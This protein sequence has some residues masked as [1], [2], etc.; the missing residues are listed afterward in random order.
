LIRELRAPFAHSK[1]SRSIIGFDLASLGRSL[2]AGDF[3][4]GAM[5]WCG[6]QWRPTRIERV[7][8]TLRTSAGPAIVETD[9]GIAYLKGIGNP[10]G[11]VALASELVAGELARWFG[12][13]TPDFAIVELDLDIPL[14]DGGLLQRGPAFLSRRVDGNVFD[15][16]DRM[17]KKMNRV[18]DISRLVIFDTWIRNHDRCPPADALDPAPNRDNLILAPRGR[19]YELVVLD[20]THC[21]VEGD[22]EAAIVD[23]YA[24]EDDRIFGLFPEFER[25]I[26]EAAVLEASAHLARLDRLCVQEIVS[27]LP[28]QWGISGPMRT[29]W[30]DFIVERARRVAASGPE[31]LLRQGRLEL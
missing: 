24:V 16:T 10:A 4:E 18:A 11:D 5:P 25:F 6:G 14:R 22:L 21:F 27:S 28:P 13:V 7:V 12:L 17:L 9:A 3:R 31:R 19:K 1:L 8:E 20:H 15:G 2:G 23:R 29:N 26:T 30:V